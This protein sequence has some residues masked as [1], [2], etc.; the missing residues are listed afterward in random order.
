MV[1][2]TWNARSR[3][4]AGCRTRGRTLPLPRSRVGILCRAGTRAVNSHG[5]DPAGLTGVDNTFDADA[6]VHRPKWPTTPCPARRH[7]SPRR[8][9]VRAQRVRRVRP[10][11]QRVGWV[12]DWYGEGY[13]AAVASAAAGPGGARGKGGGGGSWH[14][15]GSKHAA[16]S[17]MQTRRNALHDGGIRLVSEA[18]AETTAPRDARSRHRL[19][20]VTASPGRG[21]RMAGYA[22]HPTWPDLQ[23]STGTPTPTAC[24]RSPTARPPHAFTV[25]ME[26]ELIEPSPARATTT[27][28]ALGRHGH[29]RPF[30]PPAWT[31][32]A[33]TCS[34]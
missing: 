26:H 20:H 32:I 28:F 1:N 9:V 8:G 17:A 22:K 12:S 34:A 13:Y 19:T 2:V 7:A 27:R 24:S 18:R 29:G 31:S 30:L 14:T 11:R 23:H 16:R 5:D 4:P 21:V 25:E 6:A 15:W 10:A 33:G 3:W